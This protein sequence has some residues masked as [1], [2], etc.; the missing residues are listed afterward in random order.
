MTTRL[1][2]T[3]N[4]QRRIKARNYHV[5]ATSWHQW[6]DMR[7][8]VANPGDSKRMVPV[9]VLPADRES[10]ERMVE[11]MARAMCRSVIDEDIDDA[12]H[13]PLSVR[14]VYIKEARAALAN[15]GIT[16]KEGK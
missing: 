8:W 15:I 7:V 6:F 2:T 13:V 11:Q 9:F 10:V 3:K 5:Y 4:K 1:R 14:A 16:A 12:N